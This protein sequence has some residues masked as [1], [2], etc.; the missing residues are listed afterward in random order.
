MEQF[1]RALDLLSQVLTLPPLSQRSDTQ[2]FQTKANSSLVLQMTFFFLY[3]LSSGL[4]RI[5]SQASNYKGKF[6]YRVTEVGEVSGRRNELR[7]QV[8]E[9]KEGALGA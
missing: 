7:K 5:Q 6:T 2:P 9:S 8:T 1:P 3:N 4:E